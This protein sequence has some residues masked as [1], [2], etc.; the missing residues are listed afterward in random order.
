MTEGAKTKTGP[1]RLRWENAMRD[2][3]LVKLRDMQLL[4]TRAEHFTEALESGTVSTNM[5]LRRQHSF[6]VDT[7]WLPWPVLP[8]KFWP[9][10]VYGDKR[11]I[12]LDAHQRILAAEPKPEVRDYYELLWHVGGSQ[13]DMAL[14]TKENV[15]WEN[16]TISYVRV[17]TG[18]VAIVRFNETLAEVLKR[19][20]Q[21]GYLFPLL[22]KWDQNI[23]A[24]YFR[25]LLNRLKIYGISLHSYRYAW[26]ER[27][28]SCGFTE[29]FAQ[30]A[31]GHSSKLIARAYAK[32]A[33]VLVPPL[34][35][36]ER[37]YQNAAG[38]Q[39]DTTAQ[40]TIR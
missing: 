16:R 5:F 30:E 32:K 7:G 35:D 2:K 3:A 34:E 40:F 9:K 26:A 12:T 36:Y 29:R 13:T 8:R 1:T 24:N 22:A 31:L 25:R 10:I 33:K 6:A 23:R 11:G 39:P 28:K 14:L 27:A 19:R 21:D 37:K 20:N 38:S 4:Q 18:Q 15:D 17:K